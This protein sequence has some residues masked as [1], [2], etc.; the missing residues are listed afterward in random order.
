MDIGTGK[1]LIADPFLKDPNFLRSVV[2]LCNHQ[3]EGSFGFVMNRKL[4]E[5]IGYM[6]E[7]LEG[8][9]FPVYYGGPVQKDMLQFI[10]QRPDLIE[11][12]IEIKN[13]IYL[14]GDF[15]EVIEMLKL[16]KLSE[17]MIRFYLGYSGWGEGQLA[18]E[19]KEK[20]WLTADADKEL[21]FHNNADMIWKDAVKKL[22][23][24]YEQII[25][26]PIDPQL[27]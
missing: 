2:L 11:G 15:E 14:G 7:G 25:N 6:M 5:P 23:A 9:M 20:T 10:H 21:V 26:Y 22:G 1:L 24:E 13:G 12:G 18:N 4:S 16:N 3:K 17:T 19:M 27:N 8:C